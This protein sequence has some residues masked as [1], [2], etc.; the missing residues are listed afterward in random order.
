MSEIHSKL[1]RSLDIKL[2][3]EGLELSDW[4]NIP[5]TADRMVRF[6]TLQ[7]VLDEF[8]LNNSENEENAITCLIHV[9]K[10]DKS[11]QTS[12]ATKEDIDPIYLNDGKLNVPYL[13]ENAALLFNA[14]EYDAAFQIYKSLKKQGSQTAET[15]TGIARCL[16]ALQKTDAAIKAYEEAIT[17]NPSL[18]NY[19]EYAALLSNV[20][21]HQS[22]A[23]AIERCLVQKGLSQSDKI[24]VHTKAGNYWKAAKQFQ[25]AE[26]HFLNALN[27]DSNS[28]ETI[29]ALS[30]NYLEASRIQDSQN[31]LLN[32]LDAGI[33]SVKIIENLAQCYL[34]SGNKQ[35]ALNL[36]IEVLRSDINRPKTLFNM[37][38]L[39]YQTKQ[40]RDA[41]DI[42]NRYVETSPF[43]AHLLYSLAGLRY[44]LGEK[45]ESLMTLDRL[46]NLKPDYIEATTL[47]DHILR[48]AALR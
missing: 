40:Y 11:V 30:D 13:L 25:K 39:S 46:L 24:F 19:F 27:I 26:D 20:T 38:Q 31:L 4:V 44:H 33:K 23:E 29:E 48:S 12:V 14:K 15:L 17:Y 21:R 28:I 9:R 8:D 16:K 32:A 34:S 35:D 37:I 6:R 36:Y 43:N 22:A 5:K 42:L 45:Q 10:K 2:N 41:C 3:E 47:R 1:K 18:Q 7:E